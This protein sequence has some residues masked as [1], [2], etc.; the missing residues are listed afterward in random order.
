MKHIWKITVALLWLIR[1]KTFLHL[2]LFW[3]D[4][5]VKIHLVTSFLA[6]SL[7]SDQNIFHCASNFQLTWKVWHSFLT[8]TVH[9]VCF[10]NFRKFSTH[11]GQTK[12]CPLCVWLKVSYR[13]IG[14][15]KNFPWIWFGQ[16]LPIFHNFEEPNEIS[17]NNGK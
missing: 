3:L 10:W 8:K 11:L 16:R 2:Q 15:T 13:R 7:W 5:F 14:W 17:K 9:S 1:N 12:N 6:F 4:G